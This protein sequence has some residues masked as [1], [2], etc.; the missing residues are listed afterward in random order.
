MQRWEG[1][2]AAYNYAP[3]SSS[4]DISDKIPFPLFLHRPGSFSHFLIGISC[5]FLLIIYSNSHLWGWNT[6]P[7][8]MSTPQNDLI[9]PSF[10]QALSTSQA[11]CTETKG[12]LVPQVSPETYA[13]PFLAAT[14][15]SFPLPSLPPWSPME[16]ICNQGTLGAF[17][18]FS[19]FPVFLGKKQCRP[20]L[21]ALQC[22]DGGL[23][24]CN[25]P[26]LQLSIWDTAG[27]VLQL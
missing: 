1:Y 10:G 8:Q 2:T 19:R 3:V 7:R 22:S 21:A 4:D 6:N 5:N 25:T 16:A 14:S 13:L 15:S 23:W 18:F 26:P 12:S 20:L 9:K 11:R 17:Q 24:V 27:F